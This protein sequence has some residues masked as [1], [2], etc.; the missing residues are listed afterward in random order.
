MRSLSDWY[1][2]AATVPTALIVRFAYLRRILRRI[3]RHNLALLSPCLAIFPF[4]RGNVD[5]LDSLF[6]MLITQGGDDKIALVIGF[7]AVVRLQRC[8]I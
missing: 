7:S 4:A 8:V 1:S 2:D 3:L 6:G 5:Y